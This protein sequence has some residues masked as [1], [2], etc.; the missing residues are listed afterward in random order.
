MSLQYALQIEQLEFSW[1]TGKS[2]QNQPL[3]NIEHLTLEQGGRLFVQGASGSGKSTLLSLL[4]GI[5]IPQQGEITLLGQPMSQLSSTKR[6]HF[7]ARHIG[8]VFQQFNLLPYLSVVENVQLAGLFAGHKQTDSGLASAKEYL[9]QLNIPVSLFAR[10]V[11]QLSVGQQQ[12][13]AIARALYNKPEIIIADEPTSA[14]DKQ[15]CAGFMQMLLSLVTEIGSTLIFVSHD[16]ALQA[17]F[18]QVLYLGQAGE[19]Q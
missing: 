19:Q 17:E 11:S 9:Q 2:A 13:V 7:R 14:L 12:R 6:D 16:P 3:I 15:N 8:Y 1:P 18:E 5:N 10:P 4:A